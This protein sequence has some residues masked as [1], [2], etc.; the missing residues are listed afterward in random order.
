MFGE[1]KSFE[2]CSEN[3]SPITEFHYLFL[4]YAAIK[5]FFR[6][7]PYILFMTE[8]NLKEKNQNALA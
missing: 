7:D 1:V 6:L 4:F 8:R 3:S 5:L 2:V